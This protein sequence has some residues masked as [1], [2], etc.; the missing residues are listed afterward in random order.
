MAYPIP[1]T[2][3]E[4]PREKPGQAQPM[5]RIPEIT[6]RAFCETPEIIGVLQT[7][8]ADRRMSRA[9]CSVELGGV[10]AAIDSQ[11]RA[12]SPNLLIIES[13]VEAVALYAKLDEF[14]DV[15]DINTKVIV[16]GSV[17]DVALYRE[18]LARGVSDYLVSPI[19]PT[20]LID[21]VARLYQEP[22][23]KKLGRTLAFVGAKGGV[24]SSS[25]AHNVASTLA[26]RYA[27]TVALIDMD[28]P[29][30]SASINFNL[31]AAE[32]IEQVLEDTTRVD[33]VFLERLLVKHGDHLRILTAPGLLEHSH[34]VP[35]SAFEHLLDVAQSN[36]P[37]VVLDVPHIWAPWT[38]KL[39]SLADEVV[40]TAT[41][42]LTNLRNS[43]SLIDILKKSRP[44]D[45]PPKLVLNQVGVPKRSEITSDKFAEVLQ[46]R[47]LASVPFEPQPFSAAINEGKPIAEI[48]A[49]A[50][51]CAAFDEIAEA[52]SGQTRPVDKGKR[53]FSFSR[54]WG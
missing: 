43:K 7:A 54:L 28:L 22:G 53:V 17:N 18:L 23:T 41:P 40:I 27:R 42:D 37:F 47:P 16:I 25:I 11:R 46:V 24:G 32:G 9:R 26:R 48:S 12:A 38:R 35:E 20:A 2:P 10:A 21:V 39:M 5:L 1:K 3:S 44:N 19:D 6:I 13:R 4:L 50:A 36:I 29:F 15:C 31:R 30:G 14:S 8:F 51:A 33:E 45:G 34:D 49:K 52:L